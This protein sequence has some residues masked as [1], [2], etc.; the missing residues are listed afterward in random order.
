MVLNLITYEVQDEQKLK[1]LYDLV[2][3]EI[4]SWATSYC[5]ILQ[6]DNDGR[7]WNECQRR[8]RNKITHRHE[9]NNKVDQNSVIFVGNWKITNKI[10]R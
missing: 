7:V 3:R 4:V 1:R 5:D 6:V 9:I 2:M 8:A 10:F